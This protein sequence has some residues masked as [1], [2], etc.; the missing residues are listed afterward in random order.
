MINL[1]RE[2]GAVVLVLVAAGGHATAQPAQPTQPATSDDSAP[3]SCPPPPGES[4]EACPAPQQAPQAQAQPQPLPP[5]P[6]GPAPEAQP[7]DWLRTVGFGLSAGGGVSD[8]T[9]SA[10]RS[11]TSTGGSWT[12]NAILGTR[13]YLAGEI[14]YIGSAQSAN[15]L[16]AAVSNQ[17]LTLVGNGAQGDLRFNTMIHSTW[18]PFFFGGV[19]WRHYSLSSNGPVV[20]DISN[21]NNVL[22]VPAGLGLAAYFDEFMVDVRGD[23]R[24]SWFGSALEPVGQ[25]TGSL[26]RWD[27][28]ATIGYN[29]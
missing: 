4:N 23:Y 26:N 29:Y 10:M 3:V 6:P 1:K 13:S 15:N 16:T 8:F 25:G 7:E 9:G 11:E 27:V 2:L 12:V 5:P 22:E 18:Q 14:A 28:A 19:A 21:G 24:F 17:S 20:G